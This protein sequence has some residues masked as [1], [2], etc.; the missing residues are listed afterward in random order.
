MHRAVVLSNYHRTVVT[1]SV[2]VPDSLGCLLSEDSCGEV[3]RTDPLYR[4]VMPY[5]NF[6]GDVIDIV[7]ISDVKTMYTLNDGKS[8]VR[9]VAV[10]CPVTYKAADELRVHGFV[11]KDSD[12]HMCVLCEVVEHLSARLLGEFDQAPCFP[13]YETDTFSCQSITDQTLSLSTQRCFREEVLAETLRR[14]PESSRGEG[15]GVRSGVQALHRA[16]Q[17]NALC[18]NATDTTE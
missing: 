18:C 4:D 5:F 3:Y 13:R 10:S 17:A 11:G 6:S 8:T 15:A 12:G 7:A 9:A 14:L 1:S 2:P 16:P